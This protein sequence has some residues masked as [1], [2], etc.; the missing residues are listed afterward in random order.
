MNF[1]ESQYIVLMLII[2]SLFLIVIALYVYLKYQKVK[3]ENAVTKTIEAEKTNTINMLQDK[4]NA[5]NEE[6]SELI[7]QNIRMQ[8]DILC[9]QL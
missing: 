5:L 1:L 2:I 3:N 7:A 4:I 8:S 6:N 9:Y